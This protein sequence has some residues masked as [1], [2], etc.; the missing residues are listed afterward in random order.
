VEQINH[1]YITG[2]FWLGEGVAAYCDSDFRRALESSDRSAEHFRD[3]CPGAWWEIDN[4]RSLALYSLADMG[5]V[6]ELIRRRPAL[7]RD[8]QDRGDLY[9]EANL[10]TYCSLLARLAADEPDEADEEVSQIMVRWSQQGFHRQHHDALFARVMIALYRSRGVGP[11]AWELIRDQWIHL[12]S[13]H[14][15]RMPLFRIDILQSR[16]RTAIAAALSSSE[17]RFLLRVAEADARRLEAERLPCPTA[18]AQIVR[19]GVAGARGNFQAARIHLA[20]AADRFNVLDMRLW[21]W[22]AR[23]RLGS[24]IGGREGQDLVSQ[25]DVW[26]SSQAIR[27]PARMA[28]MLCPGFPD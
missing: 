11:S 17:P 14:L 24:L 9:A 8:A 13:S 26:M 16:G 1:P 22:A 10:S 2:L 15:L 18:L 20:S 12:R 25:A 28:A 19:V 21:E 6:A 3:H 27:N 23:R 7:V 4:A 5:E